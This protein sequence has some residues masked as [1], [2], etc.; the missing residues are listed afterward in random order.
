MVH[1]FDFQLTFLIDIDVCLNLD[2]KQQKVLH[3]LNI[4]RI[5]TLDMAFE[6]AIDFQRWEEGVAFGKN[7]IKGLM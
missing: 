2:K 7:F 5:K 6:A 4:W 3:P 1:H